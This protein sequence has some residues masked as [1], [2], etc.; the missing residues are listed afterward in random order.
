MS[1]Y[2][3]TSYWR[4]AYRGDA[5]GPTPA[6]A[7][8]AVEVFR[9]AGVLRPCV[10][11]RSIAS[12][13][14]AKCRAPLCDTVCLAAHGLDHPKFAV[15]IAPFRCRTCREEIRPDGRADDRRKNYCSMKCRL[16]DLAAISKARRRPSWGR[17]T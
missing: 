11:C 6:P 2:T 10:V 17:A 3:A 12:G 7:H 16:D 1:K 14:C 8:D 4:P 13:A 9:S 5:G 15:A